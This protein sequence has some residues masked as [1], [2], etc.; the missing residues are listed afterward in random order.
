MRDSEIR[1]IVEESSRRLLQ[2]SIAPVRF[3]LLTDVLGRD[4]KERLV[5][6][7][8]EDCRNFPRRKKLLETMNED[9]T[10]PISRERRLAEA[11]GS[12]PPVGWTYITMLRNLYELAEYRTGIDEGYVRNSLEKILSWQTEDGFIPGPA[13]AYFPDTHYNGYALRMLLKF[14]MGKDSRVRKLV[15]WLL[16]MHRPDGGWL[17]PYLQDLRY[18]APYNSMSMPSFMNQVRKL[19]MKNY[20]PSDYYGAPSCIWTT[21]MVVRGFAQSF[22]LSLLPEVKQGAEYFLD[23]FFMR[24]HYSSFYRSDE[25]WTKLKY[26]TYFGSGLCAL[27][28]LTWMG[29]GADDPRLEKPIAWLISKRMRD[30][31]WSQSDRPHPEKDQWISE[32]SLSILNRYSQSL[33]GLPFGREAEI[34]IGRKAPV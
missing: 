19:G 18:F 13:S 3:Y 10:W 15:S 2:I 24:N 27:D 34:R 5:E 29:Y 9:G 33:R 23:R 14:G 31:L 7:T 1:G 17:I 11:R 4:E 8:L 6:Q 26:P 12:G 30:G 28:I 16:K 22:E 20:A 25:N 32:V 21:M